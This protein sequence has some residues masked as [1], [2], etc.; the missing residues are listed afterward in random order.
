MP[1]WENGLTEDLHIK[2]RSY[3]SRTVL[4][5]IFS[6]QKLYTFLSVN[7]N[8]TNMAIVVNK[9]SVCECGFNFV[10]FISWSILEFSK[11]VLVLKC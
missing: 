1:L 6:E 4:I 11:N 9:E 8:F 10:F 7:V 5:I 2:W 3:D